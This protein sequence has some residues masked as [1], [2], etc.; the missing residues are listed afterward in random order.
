MEYLK[1][2]QPPLLV[3]NRDPWTVVLRTEESQEPKFLSHCITRWRC[4]NGWI[5][6]K[7]PNGLWPPPLIFGKSCW[8]PEENLDPGSLENDQKWKKFP[9]NYEKWQKIAEITAK[10][11]YFCKNDGRRQKRQK[12]PYLDSTI[13][14]WG[15]IKTKRPYLITYCTIYSDR[16][17]QTLAFIDQTN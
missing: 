14:S 13:F 2:R 15:L 12:F 6:G 8:G 9:Q 16:T 5:F 4:Q 1:G 10:E 3:S 7:V 11:G 17:K